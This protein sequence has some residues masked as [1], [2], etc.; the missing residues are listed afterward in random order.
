MTASIKLFLGTYTIEN[1]LYF[2]GGKSPLA[3]NIIGTNLVLLIWIMLFPLLISAYTNI[4]IFL[5]L[6]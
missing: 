6:S 2:L 5:Y 3:V 1:S 4:L